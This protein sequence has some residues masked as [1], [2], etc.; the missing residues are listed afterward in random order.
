MENQVLRNVIQ[1]PSYIEMYHISDK[2]F[3]ELNSAIF[4]R[5]KNLYKN[6]KAIGKTSL[7]HGVSSLIKDRVSEIL[8]LTPTLNTQ[9]LVEAMIDE[10]CH[11]EVVSLLELTQVKIMEEG[12]IE[13][14]LFSLSNSINR[15]IAQNYSKI[16]S[17]D[18]ETLADT[19]WNK[20]EPDRMFSGISEM[21]KLLFIER[22]DYVFIAGRPS[23]GKTMLALNLLLNTGFGHVS[24]WVKKEHPTFKFPKNVLFFSV[25][26][27][28]NKI[29]NRIISCETGIPMDFVKKKIFTDAEFKKVQNFLTKFK[30]TDIKIVDDV[31]YI[32]DI[33]AETKRNHMDKP[34]DI[35]FIDHLGLLDTRQKFGNDKN[36]S[37]GYISRMLKRLSIEL[38]CVVIALSQLSRKVEERESKIPM[39]SDL[40]DSGNLEQD[41]DIVLFPFRPYYYDRSLPEN[42]LQLFIAKNRDGEVGNFELKVDLEKQKIE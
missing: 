38:N 15:I 29:M 9:E 42:E 40:R 7:T 35:I 33:I 5:V 31:F 32:E 11:T 12:N 8:S 41:A 30:K 28:V 19:W 13:D 4:L 17:C 2:I 27:P 36:S 21:D 39:L 34:I 6:K 37:L 3:D 10:S 25:E 23:Q 26:M 14:N 20:K 22:G 16:N 24:D 1:N 18:A